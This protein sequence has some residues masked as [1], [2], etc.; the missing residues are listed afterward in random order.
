MLVF[1]KFIDNFFHKR[2]IYFIS[3]M[4]FDHY[5]IIGMCDRPFTS[6][7]N[8]NQTLINNW[9][10]TVNKRDTVYFL[11]DWSFGREH[12]SASYWK[13]HLN[14]TI[15]TVKGNH[16]RSGANTVKL[17]GKKYTYLLIHN[18][19]HV[20]DWKGWVIHGHK[21]NKSPFIDGN[22][23]RINVSVELTGYAPIC[24]DTIES[25]NLTTIKLMRTSNSR[26]ERR[27]RIG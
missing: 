26:P 6:K 11:G 5:N 22:R 1:R 12:R 4:H 2:S 21:H 13:K 8:M 14:G 27:K 10:N 19:D 9:N 16:D 23:K 18:P 7:Y 20:Q 17:R 3:D 24:L 25:L 15:I